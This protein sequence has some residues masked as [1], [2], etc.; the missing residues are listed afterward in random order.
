MSVEIILYS[1]RNVFMNRET[2]VNSSSDGTLMLRKTSACN[3]DAIFSNVLRKV[4]AAATVRADPVTQ[5]AV[6]I[7]ATCCAP[8]DDS[9]DRSV[10]TRESLREIGALD[11]VHTKGNT[12]QSYVGKHR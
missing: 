9:N 7:C 11:D 2:L 1:V 6:V 3:G 4:Q 8:L 10:P 5:I 12:T